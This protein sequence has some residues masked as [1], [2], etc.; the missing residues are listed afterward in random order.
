VFDEARVLGTPTTVS[1]TANLLTA[2]HVLMGHLP[3]ALADWT[4]IWIMILLA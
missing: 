4:T 2:R 1:L 3:V